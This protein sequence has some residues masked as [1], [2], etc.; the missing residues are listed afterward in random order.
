[1]KVG[2]MVT[3]DKFCAPPELYGLGIITEITLSNGE[4]GEPIRARVYW[5][6][7]RDWKGQTVNP[8]NGDCAVR[9][10]HKVETK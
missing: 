4:T 9:Y 5:A 3:I 10:L 8:R 1:M 6:G 2:D 7:S